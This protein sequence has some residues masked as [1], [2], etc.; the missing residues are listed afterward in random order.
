MRRLTTE[1]GGLGRLA[2]TVLL[3]ICGIHSFSTWTSIAH[4]QAGT[5]CD[6]TSGVC[7]LGGQIRQQS[8]FGLPLPLSFEPAHTGLITSQPGR[9]E[10][11]PNAAVTMQVPA[12]ATGP[13][14]LRIPPGQMKYDGPEQRI[15]VAGFGGLPQVFSTVS[16]LSFSWPSSGA[17]TITFR[18]GG[19]SGPTQ[20]T[21][22]NPHPVVTWCAGAGVPTTTFNPGCLA[23]DD[24]GGGNEP[25]V[26]GLVRYTATRHQFGGAAPTRIGG[27]GD[28][29]FNIGL[30]P[31]SA[32][33]CNGA[34]CLIA[35][36]PFDLAPT[37]IRGATFSA[38]AVHGDYA[39]LFSRVRTASLGANGT[40]L[41]TGDVVTTG[42]TP[43]NPVVFVRG[44]TQ[45]FG[46]PWTT[47]RLTISV[48]DAPGGV[49]QIFV[50]TGTDQRNAQGSGI[51]TLVAGSVSSRTFSGPSNANRAWLT[52][53]VPEPST[54]LSAAAALSGLGLARRRIRRST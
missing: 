41:S 2:L 7:G 22:T 24:L 42:G 8:G 18:A 40:V 46:F 21:G 43:M 13:R 44:E 5:P 19:R 23:P 3:T 50:R 29:I 33:P 34:G 6:A 10:A 25:E 39:Y 54:W 47:G 37:G 12:P 52:L 36:Y 26:N 20:P 31:L 38:R 45:S 51:I 16:D 49:D 9:I 11:T 15:R 32:L 28:Q 4:A 14:S 35:L 1:S 53:R 30:L 48:T 17:G 27:T